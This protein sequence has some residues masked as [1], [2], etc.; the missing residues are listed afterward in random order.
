MRRRRA[1]TAGGAVAVVGVGLTLTLGGG[2]GA[3]AQDG[4]DGGDAPEVATAVVERTDL[5]ER[6]ELDGTLG[7][8]DPEELSIRRPGTV[9]ALPEPGAVVDRG[10]AV[11][12]VDGLPVLL[13]IGTTPLWRTLDVGAEGRDVQVLEENL[14]ALG[15]ATSGT[16]AVDE[17]FTSSTAAAVKRW[18]KVNGLDETGIVQP[19][20]V[21]VR[22]GPVRVAARVASLGDDAGGPVLS[23]TGTERRT[24]IDLEASRQGLLAVGDAVQVVLPDGTVLDATVAA[25]GTVVT[26]GNDMEGTDPTIEIDVALADPAAAGTLDEAPVEVAVVRSQA[27]GVLAVPVEA[28]LALA[29]GGYAVERVTGGGTE[30][31]AVEAGAYAD[32]RVEITGAVAEG[33][34][35]VVPA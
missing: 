4:D 2:A 10:G 16:L 1:L 22:A 20:D 30:L 24:T 12:E 9:T 26:P 29:E 28:L 17:E 21:V 11:A 14:V 3:A 34:E 13:L 32:G 7:Y 15:H 6:E 27:E 25:I 18:Q 23:V 19:T 35:V 8:G 33:D 31:V 5:V